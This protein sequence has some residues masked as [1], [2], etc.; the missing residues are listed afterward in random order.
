MKI[1]IDLNDV[2]G[3]NYDEDGEAVGRRDLRDEVVQRISATLLSEI[4]AETK[5]AVREKVDAV[6]AD[7]VRA[8]IMTAMAQ[9]I[10]RTTAWGEK[11]GEPTTVLELVRLKLEAFLND[12]G[13]RRDSYDRSGP[14]N[15]VELVEEAAKTVLTKELQ[16]D[17]ATVRKTINTKIQEHA[18]QA[19]AA[20]LTKGLKV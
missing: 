3:I 10:Q 7:Q 19:A 17:I 8:V 13:R 4:C 20:S 9:T 14:G 2:L 5:V 12:P 18:L 11:K 1:E 6:V 16:A 15:L